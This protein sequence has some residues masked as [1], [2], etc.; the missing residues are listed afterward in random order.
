MNTLV[1]AVY[2]IGDYTK[3]LWFRK[4]S[5][6]SE[7]LDVADDGTQMFKLLSHYKS[8]GWVLQK[9]YCVDKVDEKVNETV[10]C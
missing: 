7:I 6:G 10:H 4:L 2:G 9:Y 3:I 8:R 5:D 1:V